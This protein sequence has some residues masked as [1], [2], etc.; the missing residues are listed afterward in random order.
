[1]STDL[2]VALVPSGGDTFVHVYDWASA[3]PGWT[4]IGPAARLLEDASKDV[5]ERVRESVTQV[6]SAAWDGQSVTMASASWIVS[7]R[8]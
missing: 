8:N 5:R 2:I 7:A 4:Q 3:S 1:M 6:L